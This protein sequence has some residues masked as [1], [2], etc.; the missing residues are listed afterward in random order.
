MPIKAFSDFRNVTITYG[1][2]GSQMPMGAYKAVLEKVQQLEN[3]VENG[4]EPDNYTNGIMALYEASKYKTHIFEVTTNFAFGT[5]T[6]S[7]LESVPTVDDSISINP[8]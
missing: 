1:I 3:L 5:Y 4:Q 2:G 7:Y 8:E 6:F